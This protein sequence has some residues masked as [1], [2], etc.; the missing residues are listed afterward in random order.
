[1][2]KNV[3]TKKLNDSVYELRVIF[4][5]SLFYANM[6]RKNKEECTHHT[7]WI[8]QRQ[9]AAAVAAKN[10]IESFFSPSEINWSLS[11]KRLSCLLSDKNDNSSGTNN[12]FR[13]NDD[14]DGEKKLKT[15]K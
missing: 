11:Y 4:F 3:R 15:K 10:C 6:N 9:T 2:T 8:S 7:Y 5:R 13:I 14:D 12:K 1:M